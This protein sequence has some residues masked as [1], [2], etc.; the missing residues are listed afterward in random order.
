[1]TVLAQEIPV[2]LW[3]EEECSCAERAA[4]KLA[5][6]HFKNPGHSGLAGKKRQTCRTGIAA[7]ESP[8][9]TPSVFSAMW[10]Y[11]HLHNKLASERRPNIT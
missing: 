8:E 7:T 4:T 11:A 1:M 5:R 2:A 9:E 6:A 10:A 3:Q